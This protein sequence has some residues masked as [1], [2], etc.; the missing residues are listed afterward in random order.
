MSHLLLMSGDIESNPGP[1]SKDQE[2]QL[3]SVLSIVQQL[4]KGQVTVLD[5]IKLLREDQKRTETAVADLALRVTT[6]E[7]HVSSLKE[8]RQEVRTTETSVLESLKRLSV[9]ESRCE[10]AENRLRRSN[11]I[12]FGVR[13]AEN[14]TWADSENLVLETC[15]QRLGVRLEGNCIERA[16]RIGHFNSRKIRPIIVKFTNT[17]HKETLLG[18]AHKLKDTGYSLSEDYS[19]AVRE[20]RRKLLE[21]ARAQNSKFK[22]RFNKLIVGNVCYMYDTVTGSVVP[23]GR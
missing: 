6:V 14:E 16:H 13:D 10:D 1:M 19:P 9:V 11:L 17:K 22:L 3:N 12:F 2:A 8:L 4:Q 21:F 5:E 18:V 7:A 15:A 20:A 23:V